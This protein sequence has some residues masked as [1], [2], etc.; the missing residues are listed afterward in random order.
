M[1]ISV[2]DSVLES[3]S[4]N[5]ISDAF[6]NSSVPTEEYSGFNKFLRDKKSFESSTSF[7]IK[8]KNIQTVNKSNLIDSFNSSFR[9]D[10]TTKVVQKFGSGTSTDNRNEEEKERYMNYQYNNLKN[11][12][13]TENFES[14]IESNAETFIRAL[15]KKD[16]TLAQQLISNLFYNSFGQKNNKDIEILIGILNI[17]SHLEINNKDYSMLK[18]IALAAISH[19]NDDVKDYAVQCFENWNDPS[20]IST[21]KNIQSQASWLQNYIDKVIKSLSSKDVKGES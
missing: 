12:L 7:E 3:T 6:F 20:D 13:C 19:K 16:K 15:L 4:T 9:N 1:V 8:T 17:I 2:L 14:G 5:G 11:I 18:V 10:L 21:L